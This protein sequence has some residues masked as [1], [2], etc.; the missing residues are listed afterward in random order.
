MSKCIKHR[1]VTLSI[2]VA[3]A[4]LGLACSGGSDLQS[5]DLG[6]TKQAYVTPGPGFQV[7]FQGIAGTLWESGNPTKDTGGAMMAATSPSIA[8]LSSGGFEVAFQGD[9][10]YMW[11]TGNAGVGNTW[12]G[13][14]SAT[15][16]SIAALPGGGYEIAFQA[17]THELWVN[18]S[19]G[20]GSLGYP[21]MP[22]TNPA[23]I[24]HG[25][26]YL[27]YFQHQNGNL[28]YVGDTAGN[29][30][31]AHWV[32]WDT[33]YPMAPHTSPTLVA[34]NAIGLN[35]SSAA[36]EG[37]FQHQNGHVHI[38]G[39]ESVKELD[40]AMAPNT[41]PSIARVPPDQYGIERFKIAFHG[42][43][44]HGHHLFISG[45]D[46]NGKDTYDTGYPI[47]PNTSP[48]IAM[49]PNGNW[50]VAFQRTVNGQGHLWFYGTQVTAD[51]NGLMRAGTSPS[52]TAVK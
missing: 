14:D 46:G 37:A 31:P 4:P 8:G 48:S 10:T 39:T 41:S 38:Y 34:I 25:L 47:T 30:G 27:I 1:F 35:P 33:G 2:L 20:T 50:E 32:A 21:M 13:L 17:N 42:D 24:A 51:T 12:L 6:S 7:A 43:A 11:I 9:K 40:Y 18:G 52:I 16:P 5:E 22:G 29:A 15:S 45:G 26:S 49:S 36:F 23:I 19:A 28:W 3:L 44:A